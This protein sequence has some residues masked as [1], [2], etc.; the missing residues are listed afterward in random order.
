MN[1]QVIRQHKMKLFCHRFLEI[2]FLLLFYLKSLPLTLVTRYVRGITDKVY[3]M[4]NTTLP[5]PLSFHKM[6]MSQIKDPGLLSD[7]H[8][9]I[10]ETTYELVF[11]H[12]RGV[13]K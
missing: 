13:I 2:P 10:I 7:N 3:R 6:E 9:I 5:A 11:D 4:M 12:K 8:F 1:G